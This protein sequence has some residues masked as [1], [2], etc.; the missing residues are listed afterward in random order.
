M[1][2]KIEQHFL[3]FKQKTSWTVLNNQN[4]RG[5]LKFNFADFSWR[6]PSRGEGILLHTA[7][8]LTPYFRINLQDVPMLARIIHACGTS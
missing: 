2:S 4:I 3:K 8:Y 5:H 1:E 7:E 6:T